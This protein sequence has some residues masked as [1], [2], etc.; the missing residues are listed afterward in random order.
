MQARSSTEGLQKQFCLNSEPSP[1]SFPI[2]GLC[3]SAGG[4]SFVRG[5]LDIIKLN[6]TSLIYSVSRFTLGGWSFVWG[7]KPT[8]A[9]PWR[10][11][12][13]SYRGNDFIT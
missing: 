6:K 9:S 10:R 3:S 1:E 8:K 7:G 4:F 11:D 12:C 5:G 2:G 13:L